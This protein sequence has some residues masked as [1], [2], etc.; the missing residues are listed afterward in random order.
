MGRVGSVSKK[1]VSF[2]KK[3]KKHGNRCRFIVRSAFVSDRRRTRFLRAPRTR[4]GR[5]IRVRHPER[6]VRTFG[7]RDQEHPV[8]GDVGVL[9][10][11]DGAGVAVAHQRRVGGGLHGH[12][13]TRAGGVRV[14]DQKKTTGVPSRSGSERLAKEA[15]RAPARGR[16]RFI[17]GRVSPERTSCERASRDARARVTQSDLSCL[18]FS[19]PSSITSQGH[20]PADRRRRSR[21]GRVKRM[22]N[23]SFFQNAPRVRSDAYRVPTYD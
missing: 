16:V 10:V 15:G 8:L 13:A 3:K 11:V 6:W 23:R 22:S 7:R 4:L 17:A 5:W 9:E 21:R 2:T 20:S 12:R 1:S 14:Q 19:P 18:A